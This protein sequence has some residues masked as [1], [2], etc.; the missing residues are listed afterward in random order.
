MTFAVTAVYH[1]PSIFFKKETPSLFRLVRKTSLKAFAFLLIAAFLVAEYALI[2]HA[3]EHTFADTDEVC[4][5]CEKSDNFQNALIAS[6][7][8]VQV[9]KATEHEDRLPITTRAVSVQGLFYARAPPASGT[10]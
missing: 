10:V 8:P 1:W 6:I 2:K 9:P 5:V 4:F 7:A 3:I